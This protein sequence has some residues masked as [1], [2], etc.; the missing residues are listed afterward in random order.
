MRLDWST[1]RPVSFYY[2]GQFKRYKTC[3]G[4]KLRVA[5]CFYLLRFTD[6]YHN[7]PEFKR[8]GCQQLILSWTKTMILS[9][10]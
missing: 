4:K 2:E 3:D 6:F 8:Y 9:N 7:D 10:I 1:R 5:I